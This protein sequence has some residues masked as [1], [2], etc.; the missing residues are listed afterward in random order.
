M[1]SFQMIKMFIFYGGMIKF[2]IIYDQLG[3]FLYL[4]KSYENLQSN[5]VLCETFLNMW[6]C[7]NLIVWFLYF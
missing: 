7:D 4:G 3:K 5:S 2:N 6:T 1:F